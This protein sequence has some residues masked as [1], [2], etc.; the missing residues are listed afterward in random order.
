MKSSRMGVLFLA[1]VVL[2]GPAYGA[3]Q[4]EEGAVA[5]ILQ[6]LKKRGIVDEAEYSRMA[7]KNSRYEK[8]QEGFLPKIE[9]SGDFRF[10]HESFFYDTDSLGNDRR[11]RFRIRYRFRLNGKA[12][13]NEYTD[14]IFRL[15]SGA[16]A[17]RSGNQTLGSAI[18]FDADEFRIARAFAQIRV[19]Q[20]WMPVQGKL[21]FE[22]G[23]VPNPFYGKVSKDI[24]LWDHDI[25]LD[26]A[27]VRYKAKPWE[28]GEVFA[29]A[30]YYI[31]DE[32]S[33]KNDPHMWAIQAGASHEVAEDVSIGGR[34]TFYSF[35]SIN[36]AF[37]L[38]GA[39]GAGSIDGSGG[40]VPNGLR[41]SDGAMRVI[42]AAAWAG[43]DGIENW[44]M[45]L[46]ANYSHNLEAATSATFNASKES[47]AWNVAFEVGDKK[48][49][50]KLGVGWWHIEANAFPSMF[51]DSDL[52]DGRTNREGLMFYASRQIM[53]NTD[54]NLTLF[55]SDAI[56]DSILI[57][58]GVKDAKRIRIQADMVFKF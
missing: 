26:G 27:T 54:L 23:K 14:V 2:A 16:V 19:P 28:G 8:E 36:N 20:E 5:E 25:N 13:V 48:K 46:F 18:D 22:I 33:T 6:I 15:R 29:N 3:E 49:Y 41:G 51:I 32:N 9:W 58:Q 4:S 43:Y 37:I 12:A 44:P 35:N 53:R 11:N 40:N 17:H 45:A 47:N 39:T 42:E 10:R 57:S 34:T 21:A 24:M 52:L 50:A 56:D 30:G 31:I 1:L 7:A 38:R 55:R